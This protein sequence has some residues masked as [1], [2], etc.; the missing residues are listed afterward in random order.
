M[1]LSEAYKTLNLPNDATQEETKKAFKTLAKKY[2]PDLNKEPGSEEKF[3]KI[4][5]AYQT[6][7]KGET[8]Q[9]NPF[10]SSNVAG[11]WSINLQ[12]IFNG[13]SNSFNSQQYKQP[14]AIPDIY[15]DQIISFKES[16][17]GC[18][19]EIKY[20]RNVKCSS[21][22]GEGQIAQN[23]GCDKCGGKGATTVKQ[24]NTVIQ[25]S[26]S[27]C[28]GKT[29][30]IDCDKCYGEGALSAETTLSIHI[31]AGGSSGS[32]LTLGNRGHFINSFFGGDQCSKLYL[33]IIVTPQEGLSIQNN[34]VHTSVNL[35]LFEALSGCV[36]T[37]P[38][39]D[40]DKDID[41]PA[42]SKNKDEIILPKL[43]I[44][45]QG[46]EIISILVEY[47]DDVSSLISVLSPK[48]ENK[49]NQ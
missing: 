36:K 49:L 21:C 25:S 46:N 32:V 26:C 16:V 37:I 18:D 35:S 4:N 9:S 44:S 33:K 30:Y 45:R 17:L 28:R 42:K 19:R 2:H 40:G 31:P 6:I 20:A 23:N 1:K 12:D 39:I 13:F 24:G 15:I 48:E 10:A 43:G 5:E 8:E 11:G 38:T 27:K 41:I 47:P 22:S 34:N 7:E 29:S 14:K 3:K